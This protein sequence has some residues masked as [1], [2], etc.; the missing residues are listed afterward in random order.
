MA[1]MGGTVER[2]FSIRE[3]V[4]AASN[5]VTTAAT[6][7]IQTWATNGELGYSGDGWTRNSL[8]L[9]TRRCLNS[10]KC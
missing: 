9:R 10:Y 8:S 6:G 5:V 4:N 3:V 7:N 2:A 1:E